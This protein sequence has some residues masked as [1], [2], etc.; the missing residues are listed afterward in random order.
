V[1][2]TVCACLKFTVPVIVPAVFD[3]TVA[4]NVTDCP[5]IAGLRDEATDVL[6]GAAGGTTFCVTGDEVLV[7]LL[8]SPP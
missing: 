8:V 4:V 2:S 5:T 6:V 7:A 3:D 1:K